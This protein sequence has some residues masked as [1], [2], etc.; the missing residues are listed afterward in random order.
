[1]PVAQVTQSGLSQAGLRLWK[2]DPP[3]RLATRTTNVQAERRHLRRRASAQIAAYDC[4]R[5]T[6]RLTLLIKEPET[7]D[8]VLNGNRGAASQLPLSRSRPG[9]ARDRPGLGARRPSTCFLQIRPSGL[10]GTTVLEFDR[11]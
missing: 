5:G 9:L 4:T 8:L 10:L 2:L 3:L 1:M 6:F 11:G 7:V